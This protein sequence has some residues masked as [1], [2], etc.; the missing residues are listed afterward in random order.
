MK[1]TLTTIVILLALIVAGIKLIE[2]VGDFARDNLPAK[3][4]N[5]MDEEPKFIRGG[6]TK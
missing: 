5:L 6:L 1:S 3:V 4:L 2:P